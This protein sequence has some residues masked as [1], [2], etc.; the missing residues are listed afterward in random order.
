MSLQKQ[1]ENDPSYFVKTTYYVYGYVT[2]T[3]TITN[4]GRD[5]KEFTTLLFVRWYIIKN[6]VNTIYPYKYLCE[7]DL[8]YFLE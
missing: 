6:K 1:Y 4:I 2:I 3:K 7:S 8:F 5:R